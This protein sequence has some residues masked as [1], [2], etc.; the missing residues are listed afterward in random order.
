M[1]LQKTDS[2]KIPEKGIIRQSQQDC[3]CFAAKADRD[4]IV[5]NHRE[6]ILTAKKKSNKWL[7]ATF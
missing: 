4:P 3:V 1:N 6:R 7:A 2:L 5:L